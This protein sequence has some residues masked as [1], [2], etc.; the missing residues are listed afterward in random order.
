MSAAE[1]RGNESRVQEFLTLGLGLGG[2]GLNRMIRMSLKEK[3]R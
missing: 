3:V 2:G 1:Q